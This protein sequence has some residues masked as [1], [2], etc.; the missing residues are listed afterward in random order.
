MI[1]FY[2][3]LIYINNKMNI[4]NE[5]SNQNYA[6]IN[7]NFILG[8][9]H[10]DNFETNLYKA[11]SIC[12]ESRGSFKYLTEYSKIYT[13]TTENIN[14]YMEYFDLKN[15]NLLTLGS[16][17][18]QILNSFFYGARDIT[19]FDIN[20]Y[21]KYYVYLKVAAISSLNY[22]EFQNFFFLHGI[23][24]CD[25]KK[26]FCKE[27][28]NKIKPNLRLFDY[29]SLLFFDELFSS[30][31]IDMI[32]DY[33]FDD[34]ER[35]NNIIKDFNVYLRDEDS[36]NKLKSIIKKI[37]FNYIHGDIFQDNIPS[38]Y[39]NIFLSNLCTITSLEKLKNLL[40]K[41]DSNN[42]KENGSILF[43]YLWDTDFYSNDFKDDWKEIYKLPLTKQVLQDFI[44]EHHNINGA[45]DFLWQQNTKEDLVLIYRKKQNIPA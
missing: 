20:P 40:Q 27:L 37:H 34:D 3:S 9:K 2:V 8:W 35:R 32:R 22:E 36:Y 25:N 23:T 18:D 42:L 28:F 17:R 24:E 43:G 11:L 41:L 10:M 38:K 26:M 1:F 7:V 30:C 16:S 31:E 5:N 6:I 29:E 19:L 39:D 33:L 12:G 13:F 21:A 15:K 44:T 14:G 4:K 45:R